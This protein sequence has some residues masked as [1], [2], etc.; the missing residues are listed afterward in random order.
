MDQC[1]AVDNDTIEWNS[2][3]E[4]TIDSIP[5]I[6]LETFCWVNKL[7]TRGFILYDSIYVKFWESHVCSDRKQISSCLVACNW[8]RRWNWLPRKMT[9]HPGVA[10]I[11]YISIVVMVVW[12]KCTLVE[13]RWLIFL[14]WYLLL[15]VDYTT[16]KLI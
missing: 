12:A 11:F 15:H 10:E 16:I 6:N 13:T 7:G 9:E 8:G 14:E 5:W 2:A 1:Q 4:W 3:Q